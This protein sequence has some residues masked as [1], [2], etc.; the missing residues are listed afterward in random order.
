MRAG[1][2]ERRES[3]GAWRRVMLATFNTRTIFK[4]RR[5]HRAIKNRSGA[6]AS[7]KGAGWMYPF[8]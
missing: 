3:L 1:G 2:G 5:R 7:K 8:A 6:R 4:R